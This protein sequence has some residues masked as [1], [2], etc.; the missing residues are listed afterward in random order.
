[1]NNDNNEITIRMSDLCAAFLRAFKPI[2]LFVLILSLLGALYGVRGTLGKQSAV[3]PARIQQAEAALADAVRSRDEAVNALNRI[4]KTEIPVVMAEIE[5][6]ESLINGWHEYMQN[7]IW[8]S[9]DPFHLGVSRMSVLL[10]SKSGE[11]LAIE[12]IVPEAKKGATIAYSKIVPVDREVLETVRQLLQVDADLTYIQELM[13]VTVVSENL[14]EIRVCF[15]DP[16]IAKNATDFLL[17]R[18]QTQLAKNND[19]YTARVVGQY[20]GFEVNSYMLGLQNNTSKDYS[21]AIAELRQAEQTLQSIKQTN[22]VAAETAVSDANAAVARAESQLKELQNQAEGGA[23]SARGN[24]KTALRYGIV[25]FAVGLVLSCVAVFLTMVFS[26]KLQNLNCALIRYAFPVVGFL[27][28]KK[29]RWFEKT[30]CKLEGEP[31]QDYESAGR[32]TAQSLFSLIGERK[33]ALVSSEGDKLIQAVLPFVE[34]KIPVCGD[35]LKDAG[36]VKAAEQY[37]GFVLVEAKGQSRV[38]LI[39]AEVRRIQTL[40]KKVEGMILL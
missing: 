1:M 6:R 2:L 5:R 29:K 32:A 8:Y 36:A 9:L 11:P 25:F 7:S 10:E 4:L 34:G 40:G 27:P 26:G 3:S 31:Y 12:E 16:D 15:D 33:V 30:I 38:G 35:L 18:L 17:E 22:K 20:T 21:V 28:G 13:Y 14:I 19:G 37:E 39:D 23:V 24:L